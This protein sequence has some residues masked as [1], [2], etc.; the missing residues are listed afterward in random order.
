MA[1]SYSETILALLDELRTAAVSQ[2]NIIAEQEQAIKSLKEEKERLQGQ[3]VELQRQL[4]AAQ[5]STDGAE[6]SR[7]LER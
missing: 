5:R 3:V 6:K 2:G 4:A 7:S 1:S